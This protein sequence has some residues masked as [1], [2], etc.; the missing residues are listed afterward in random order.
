M[1]KEKGSR[2]EC[3]NGHVYYKSSDCPVCPVC[4]KDRKPDADFLS[5]LAAPARR[6]L[7]NAGIKTLK[8]LAKF[9]EKEILA[10]HGMGPGS[11]PK[12]KAELKK[13]R[14]TFRKSK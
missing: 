7:E 13:K 2:R 9:S 4:E 3:T 8:Q 11:I 12:L 6:A 1:S 10:L 14:L 5:V